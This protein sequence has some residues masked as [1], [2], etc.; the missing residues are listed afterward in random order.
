[1]VK[2][3]VSFLHVRNSVWFISKTLSPWEVVI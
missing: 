2:Q 3:S 1:M